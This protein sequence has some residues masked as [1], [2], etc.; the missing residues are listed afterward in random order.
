MSTHR[1][2]KAAASLRRPVSVPLVGV[3]AEA[4]Y[5]RE[6]A[7]THA[8]YELA[9]RATAAA[10]WPGVVLP[11][12]VVLG[13]RVFP[14]VLPTGAAARIHNSSRPELSLTTLAAWELCGASALEP[15]PLGIVGFVSAGRRWADALSAVG[16]LGGLGAGLVARST[17]LS[18]LQVLEADALDLWAVSPDARGGLTLQ[19]TGRRG[20]VPTARRTPATRQVEEHL[21]G[22]ALRSGAFSSLS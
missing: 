2:T 12:A 17:P 1:I 15:S 14:V 7:S 21:F 6:R 11:E 13:L 19:V 18:T 20:P 5:V 10:G 9:R 4:R 16:P 22:H 8:E 3:S